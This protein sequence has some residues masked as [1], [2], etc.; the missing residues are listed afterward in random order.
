MHM[1]IWLTQFTPLKM[2]R[3]PSGQDK[4]AATAFT[5]LKSIVLDY[6]HDIGNNVG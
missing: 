5:C 3:L 4:K 2:E 1:R 6:A